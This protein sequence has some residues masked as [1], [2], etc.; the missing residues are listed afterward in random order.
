MSLWH[1]NDLVT[2]QDLM[3]YESKILTEF[4]QTDWERRRQK[5]L[6]DWLFPLME[7]R[8]YAPDRFRTR[9]AP[10]KVFSFASPTYTDQTSTADSS[11]G[12]NLA[13]LLDSSAKYLYIGAKTLFRGLSVR[14]LEA[15][16]SAAVALTVDVWADKW[17]TATVV[18]STLIGSKPFARGGSITWGPIAGVV[19]R[20]IN[21]SDSMYWMRLSF[22]AAPTGATCGP[23]AVIRRSRLTAA[24][25]FRTLMHIFEEAPVSQEGPWDAKAAKYEARSLEAWGNVVDQLGPEFDTDNDDK[26]DGDE[27]S[28]TSQE[29]TGRMGYALERG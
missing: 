9:A 23:I 25:T 8:G 29:V 1:P 6:E 13:T 4:G 18:D 5:V 2:D 28:Q 11:D 24:A 7:R 27:N 12:L 14:M 10:D 20:A 15:V 19:R 22:S 3:D 17:V 26:I 16:N 21:G